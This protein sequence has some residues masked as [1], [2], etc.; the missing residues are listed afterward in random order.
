MAVYFLLGEGGSGKSH[1]L[2]EEVIRKSREDPRSHHIVFVPEQSTFMTQQAFIKQH[3]RRAMLNIEVISFGHLARRVF[4]E[5]SAD[6]ATVLGENGKRLLL[7]LA[8]EEVKKDLTVYGGQ[9]SRPGF[10]TKLGSLFAEWDMNDISPERLLEI[11]EGE[12]I[13]PLLSAKLK[14]LAAIYRAFKRRLGEGRVTGRKCC[15]VFFACFPIR[16]PR[17][18]PVSTLTALPALRVCSTV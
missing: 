9:V 13:T 18:E 12:G 14:D 17:A 11:A 6:K 1:E 3:P 5:F 7:A 15:R 4:R 8:S 2:R 16:M 10:L